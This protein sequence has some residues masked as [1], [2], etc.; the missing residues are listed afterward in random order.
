MNPP[1]LLLIDDEMSVRESLKMVFGKDYRIEEADSAEKA[2]AKV[3][4]IKPAI[5]LL[6]VVMPK[7]DGLQLLRRLKGLHPGC[8]II[9]LTGVNSQQI[10]EKA[11][12]LGAADCVGK[13]F[14]VIELRNKVAAAWT[15]YQA[16]NPD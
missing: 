6:D 11:K 16:R 4:A 13:P 3:S 5:I 15:R 2:V 10:A 8:E 12:E 9:M 14:D 1:E 7:T